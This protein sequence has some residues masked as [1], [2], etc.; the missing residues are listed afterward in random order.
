[1]FNKVDCSGD[2]TQSKHRKKKDMT[3]L[4]CATTQQSF[5][6][7]E[8]SGSFRSIFPTSFLHLPAKLSFHSE[9]RL[10]S[11]DCNAC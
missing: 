6:F 4:F 3:N 10:K 9:I 1:M 8:Q 11:L 5:L 7:H 2:K